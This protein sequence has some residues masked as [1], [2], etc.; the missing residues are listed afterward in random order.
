MNQHGE[1]ILR[2]ALLGDALGRPFNGLKE[3]HVA[4]SV[5]GAPEG[6]LDDPVL[7]PDKP[8]RNMLPGVHSA[9]G[10]RLLAA[11]AMMGPDDAGREPVARAC[12]LLAELKGGDE[13]EGFRWGALRGAGRPL[14]RALSRWAEEYPWE[15][16]DHRAKT[17]ESEGIGAAP[18]GLVTVALGLEDAAGWALRLA[19]CTHYREMA[20]MGAVAV[21]DLTRLV[22]DSGGGKRIDSAKIMEKLRESLRLREDAYRKEHSRAWRDI[23]WSQPEAR[24]SDALS[25]V[26]SLLH[27]DN[28][29]LAIKTIVNTATECR[30]ATPVKHVQ[31]GF[32][33]ASLPWA[34]YRALGPLS[35]VHA[36]E[37]IQRRGGESSAVGA[38]VAGLMVARHG[39]ECLP[40][41]WRARLLAKSSAPWIDASAWQA[42]EAAWTQREEAMRDPLREALRKAEARDIARGK[43]DKKPTQKAGLPNQDEVPFAPPPHLWLKPGEEEDPDKKRILKEARGKR[44]IDWKEE[45]KKKGNGREN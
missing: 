6:F 39:A 27:E 23:G 8:E 35:A 33:A 11:T 34:I 41:E 37:D 3:G 21:A 12:G 9:L 19:R 5:G 26:A 22:L 45:R 25:P 43:A 38:I 40:E 28:D 29:D 20:V 18:L 30:P 24:L 14:R 17:E 44:K 4:Q 42:D 13:D 2:A 15:E 31:H 7:F 36:L 1:E 32:A 16:A 10:Q